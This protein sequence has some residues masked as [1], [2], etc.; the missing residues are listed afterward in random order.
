MPCTIPFLHRHRADT[1]PSAHAFG[2][3]LAARVLLQPGSDRESL[4]WAARTILL[5]SPDQ[6]LRAV[7]A[8]ALPTEEPRQ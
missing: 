1:P 7:A 4:G 2:L 5:H 3:Q 6:R 8:T